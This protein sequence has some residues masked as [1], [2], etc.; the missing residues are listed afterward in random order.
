MKHDHAPTTRKGWRS[1]LAL[2]G[3]LAI[4][5][6]FLLSEHRAHALGILPFVLL[7]LCPLLHLFGHGGHETH[8]GEGQ[9]TE[10][11]RAQP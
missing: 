4:G 6:F 2:L 3:F 5:A 8:N 1:G 10:S 11:R 7:L 9:H